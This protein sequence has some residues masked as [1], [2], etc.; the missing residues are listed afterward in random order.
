MTLSHNCDGTNSKHKLLIS[1]LFF[2]NYYNIYMYIHDD[3]HSFFVKIQVH[4]INYDVSC[5]DQQQN[6]SF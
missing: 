6:G 1:K 4:F 5:Y 3:V 2:F